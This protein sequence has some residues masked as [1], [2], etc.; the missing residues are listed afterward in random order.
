MQRRSPAAVILLLA[1]L[2]GCAATPPQTR[3]AFRYDYGGFAD[4]GILAYPVPGFDELP[5]RQKE[6]LYYLAQAGYAGRDIMY[7][8][9]YR[10]NLRVRRT[11][12]A[13]VRHYDGEL[14]DPEFERFMTYTRQVWFSNGIHHHYSTLKLQPAFSNASFSDYVRAVATSGELPL[15]PGE[16]VD[17]LLAELTPV[18]FDPAVA[19]KKVET[20]P[21]VDKVRASAVN[22]YAG[23]T[24]QEVRDFYAQRIDPQDPTPVSWGLNSQ[25]VKRDDGSIAER[26]WKVGGMYGQALEQVVYWLEKAA[27]VAENGRQRRSLELLIDYY[28]SGDLATFDAHSIAWVEDN[29]SRVD[30]MNGFIEVYNDPIAYRGSYEAIVSFRDEQ[31]ND[32]I[33][34][35]AANAQWFE[36]HMPI[37]QA[38]KKPRVKGILGS[39]ITVVAEAGDASPSTPVGVNLPNADW[40]RRDHGSKSVTLSNV[41]SAYYSMPDKAL[42]EFA[43]DQA[44]IA[45]AQRWR[46]IASAL[47]AIRS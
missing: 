45:R 47:R 38:H 34:T 16:S 37:M 43:W 39:A 20:A 33:A 28:R 21:G 23:V 44:E 7:D 9:N 40:I 46:E 1:A 12:E 6:L 26:A 3:E 14:R 27:A 2:A 8:Q 36:D 35:I 31:T 42:Q 17:D 11:L 4:V 19:P 18:I 5:T 24:E 25:L 41:F 22:F 32:R 30:L 13:V 10:H 29:E 15:L